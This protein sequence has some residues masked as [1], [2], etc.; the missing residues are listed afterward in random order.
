MFLSDD[1]GIDLPWLS[2]SE[3]RKASLLY[4]CDRVNDEKD[5]RCYLQALAAKM[6]DELDSLKMSGTPAAVSRFI[7]FCK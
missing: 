4:I 3:E 2:K 5:A 6:T 7:I 1:C